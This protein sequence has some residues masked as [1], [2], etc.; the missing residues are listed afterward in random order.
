MDMLRRSTYHEVEQP[1]IC[2][3]MRLAL[4][5]SLI[6]S[7]V[8]A[9]LVVSPSVH[10]STSA[11]E[12]AADLFTPVFMLEEPLGA[13]GLGGTVLNTVNFQL[14][15]DARQGIGSWYIVNLVLKADL[16]PSASSHARNYVSVDTNGR[17]AAQIKLI[18]DV[19]AGRA[20]TRWS[21]YEMFTGWASGVVFGDSII[22]HFRNYLQIQGVRPG[23]NN[24]TLRLEQPVGA[25]VS[26]VQLLPGSGVYRGELGPS[27]LA[28]DASASV[29]RL[30]V[31]EMLSLQ[32]RVTNGGFPARNVGVVAASSEPGLPAT[33]PASRFLP[34]VSRD[35]EGPISFVALAPG[36]YTVIVEAR[37]DTGG[38]ADAVEVR[39]DDP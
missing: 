1:S 9:A 16:D 11:R 31:G 25:V 2:H 36:R 24:F 38:S 34:W 6:L 10:G 13:R 22:L 18:D 17:T 21:T 32:Y 20:G 3:A 30:H 37:S 4:C 19:V 26:S 12:G 35:D 23:T 8:A 39:V 28:V 29:T 5:A 7:F 27:N 14:P 33:E 15:D